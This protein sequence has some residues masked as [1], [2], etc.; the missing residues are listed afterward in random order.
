MM[1]NIGEIVGHPSDNR[2]YLKSPTI[3]SEC[4]VGIEVEA[5]GLYIDVP[6]QGSVPFNKYWSM[7]YDGSLRNGG[8]EFILQNPL[9]GKDLISALMSLE[10]GLKEKGL[11]PQFSDNTSVHVHVDVRDLTLN[12]LRN[13]ILVYIIFERAL[14]NYAGI[15]RKDNIFCTSFDDSQAIIDMIANQFEKMDEGHFRESLNRYEKYSSCNLL[16]VRDHG[17]LEFRHHSGEIKAS[18]LLRWVNILLSLKKYVQNQRIVPNNI[19][20]EISQIGIQRFSNMVFGKY[21]A[22]LEYPDFE[23][24][25]LEGIRLAQDLIYHNNMEFKE[26]QEKEPSLFKKYL[27][28]IG[29]EL[30]PPLKE[31]DW[32]NI[33][34]EGKGVYI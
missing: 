17:S 32:F 21:A 24:G 5:E 1:R 34:F 13:F 31:D 4:L 26:Y 22:Y 10:R 30:P 20:T 28:K 33:I 3:V 29:K 19:P 16:S 2:T 14:F 7:V 27:K 9:T 12:E 8:C 11:A 15:D 18:R 6:R 23:N 25:V